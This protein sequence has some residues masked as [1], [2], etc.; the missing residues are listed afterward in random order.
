[1]MM[2]QNQMSFY[3]VPM[4]LNIRFTKTLW[5]LIH[6]N[7]DGTTD[8]TRTLHFGTPTEYQKECFTRVFKGQ[9]NLAM[10]KFP[11]KILVKLWFCWKK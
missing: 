7:R 9:A 6:L 2:Y 5:Q 8:V 11:H 10:S 4:F 1:M 3:F